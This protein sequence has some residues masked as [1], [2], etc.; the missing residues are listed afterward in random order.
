MSQRP[1]RRLSVLVRS[2]RIG[3]LWG[4]ACAWPS[5]SARRVWEDLASSVVCVS[6]F[7]FFLSELRFSYQ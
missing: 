4:T 1:A 5:L 7:V 3:H 2:R 6:V